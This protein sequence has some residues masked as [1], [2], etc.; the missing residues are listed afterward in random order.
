[1][2]FTGITCVIGA[3]ACILNFTSAIFVPVS[4][5]VGECLLYGALVL[6]EV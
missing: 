6:S 1:M 2:K 3:I 5:D 4:D